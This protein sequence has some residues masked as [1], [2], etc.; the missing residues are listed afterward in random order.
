MLVE[1][2]RKSGCLCNLADQGKIHC[3]LNVRAS[4][5]DVV[6]G[7]LFGKLQL[8]D[9][10]WWLPDLL[11]RSLG[12]SEYRQ[13]VYRKLEIKLWST[14]PLFPA[15]LLPWR[16]GRTEVDVEIRWENPATTI[17][18]EMKLGSDVSKTTSRTNG[19]EAYPSDQLI[20]NIRVGL[21][22][23]GWFRDGELFDSSK[24]RFGLIFVS[25]KPGHPLVDQYQ[26]RDK[27]IQS[28]PRGCELIDLP[29]SPIIG[30]SSYRGIS[31]LLEKNYRFMSVVERRIADG[32]REYLDLKTGQIMKK[33][34]A[35]KRESGSLKFG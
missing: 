14:Q 23:S 25:P 9:P 35:R 31:Q 33:R 11:N 8:I 34:Q 29:E 7:E 6:T 30:A 22:Q 20:R 16:E 4:S 15:E 10:R 32:L 5:E 17:F 19:S 28:I 18:I 21:H 13:Q 1:I 2:G 26:V 24:R 27:L 12:T 3:P